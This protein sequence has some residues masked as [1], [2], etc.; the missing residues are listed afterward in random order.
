M[1]IRAIIELN[2][3]WMKVKMRR[4]VKRVIC[5]VIATAGCL[6][7]QDIAKAQNEMN[8]G[9]LRNHYGPYDYTNPK[10]RSEMLPRVEQYH[11]DIGVQS[12]KGL[13]NVTGS[14]ARLGG[15]LGYTLQAFPNHHQALYTMIRYYI[16]LVP[17]GAEPMLYDPPCWLN[18]ARRF[19]PNDAT[20][21][22]LEGLYYQK[23]GKLLDARHAYE[24]ALDMN[25]ESAE[26]NYNA[27]LLFVDL[28]DYD[29]A[30]ACAKRAYEFGYPLQGL[31]RKLIKIGVWAPEG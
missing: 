20:V 15:D 22:M 16:E 3:I 6:L 4:K 1:S 31:R 10:H 27:G 25:P 2:M 26:I 30:V 11:F 7:L 24:T 13:R 12:L 29:K 5:S 28:K 8:C 21:L 18:R 9:D 14:D 23:I 17:K 19:A